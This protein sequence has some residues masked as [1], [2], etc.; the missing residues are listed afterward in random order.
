[1]RFD[2]YHT[3]DWSAVPEAFR[4]EQFECVCV[5]PE[6]PI[7]KVDRCRIPTDPDGPNWK[8]TVEVVG[9][10]GMT[11]RTHTAETRAKMSEAAKGVRKPLSVEHRAKLSAALKGRGFTPETLAKISEAKKGVLKT[12]EAR[13]KM[14]MAAKGRWLGKTHTPETRLKM[15]EAAKSIWKVRKSNATQINEICAYK[16]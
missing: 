9:T 1:M 7:S 16:D 8:D 6:P 2:N 13:A 3:V 15:S 4:P 5:N 14:K 12:P 10:N 11:G